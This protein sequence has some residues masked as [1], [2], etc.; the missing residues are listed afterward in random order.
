VVLVLL[1]LLLLLVLACQFPQKAQ[2]FPMMEQSP[3]LAQQFLW[4][5]WR[6]S[7]CQL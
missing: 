2:S 1:V 5:Q 4:E 7:L 3:V 6:R